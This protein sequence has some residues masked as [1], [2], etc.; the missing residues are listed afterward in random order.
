[1][2][3][4]L[5]DWGERLELEIAASRH[6]PFSW[7]DHDCVAFAARCVH[8]ITGELPLPPRA[9]HYSTARQAQR[10]LRTFGGIRG[11]AAQYLGAEI[12]PLLAQPGDVG[13]FME[14][15]LEAFCVEAGGVW[16][17]PGADGLRT[18]QPS[19]ILTAWRVERG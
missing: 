5:R 17:A 15:E 14:G 12:P 16:L 6:R 19:T 1:M 4:R 3:R 7:V 9:L 8:A 2:T 11:L 13:L 18:L 10:M